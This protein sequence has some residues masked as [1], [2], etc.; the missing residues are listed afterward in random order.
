[1]GPSLILGLH[2]SI[3]LWGPQP[4]CELPLGLRW[5]YEKVVDVGHGQSWDGRAEIP[6]VAETPPHHNVE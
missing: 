1:V 5:A 4:R 2:G 3:V 6:H